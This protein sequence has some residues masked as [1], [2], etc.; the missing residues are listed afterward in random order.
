[1]ADESTCGVPVHSVQEEYFYLMVHPCDC[2]GAW[3]PG[4]QHVERTARGLVHHVRASCSACGKDR[5]LEFGLPGGDAP[6]RPAAVREINPT[7]APSKAVDLAEWMDL[8]RF[9]LE[10]IGRL[11]DKVRK[12]Q[13]LL[14]ARLCLEEALKFYGPGD[15][16][17]P[18]G[19]LWSDSSRAKVAAQPDAF[20]RASVEKM[21]G[22]I[23]SK[24]RLLKVDGPVQKEFESGIREEARRRTRE[25]WKFWK[26]GRRK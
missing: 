18:A 4:D 23:P 11:K 20:R 21:L 13:S 26:W 17:P 9:Y 16:A 25:R 2:G 10:R 3:L 12:A 22:R 15:D 19:A 14:D 7:A 8:A 5:T 6:G 1:M 24:E